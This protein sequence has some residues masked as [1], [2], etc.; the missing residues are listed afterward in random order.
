MLTKKIQPEGQADESKRQG[1]LKLQGCNNHPH[2][3]HHL[4]ARTG[5]AATILPGVAAHL[6]AQVARQWARLWSMA[7]SIEKA[8]GGRLREV[9]LSA[10]NER[11]L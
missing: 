3:P 10:E 4:R 9:S 11:K 7:R 8:G 5:E 6:R 1:P 2:H